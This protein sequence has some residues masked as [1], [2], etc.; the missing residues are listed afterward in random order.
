MRIYIFWKKILSDIHNWTVSQH[1]QN[2]T[3]YSWPCYRKS[4]FPDISNNCLCFGAF[5]LHVFTPEEVTQLV[6][7]YILM[8]WHTFTFYGEVNKLNLE[9]KTLSQQDYRLQF[10][11]LT[12]EILPAYILLYSQQ[13]ISTTYIDL[14]IP[15]S[16]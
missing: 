14:R 2:K 10:W 13:K 15:F 5:L 11:Y 1:G 16:V 9:M 4:L 3:F 6:W 12:M 7:G 8:L